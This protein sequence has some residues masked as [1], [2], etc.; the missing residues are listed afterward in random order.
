[1][2]SL[3]SEGQKF[4]AYLAELGGAVRGGVIVIHEIWGLNNHTKS[5]AERLAAEGYVALAPDLLS[6]TDIAAHAAQ[7]QLDLF[8]PQK[9]NQAQPKLRALMAPMQEPGFAEKTLAKVKVC[10]EQLYQRNDTGQKVAIMGFCFGGS[11]SFS[12][13]MA[14]PRLKLALPFYG[15]TTEDVKDL[16]KI[17]CPIRAFYGQKDEGLMAS[18]P[19]LEQAMRTAGVDFAATVYP[20]CGHAFFNDTNPFAY[21]QPAAVDA[22]Q[23]V[24]SSLSQYLT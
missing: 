24:L 21:N 4:E 6:E 10:F 1:M 18:L 14:E 16:K 17:R 13:A 22:W 12:L 19:A 5:I 8:N 11:Y 20:D 3:E 7:L 2:L 9:R 15:H 23:K